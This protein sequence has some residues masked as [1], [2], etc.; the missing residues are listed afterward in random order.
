[1][2]FAYCNQKGGVG[3]TTTVYHH[4][5][6][7]ILAGM[8]VLVIDA[9]PQ[10]NITSSLTEDM[11]ESDAGVADALSSRSDL[12]LADV[13]V[14][15]IWDRL[16]VAPTVGDDLADVRNEL[17]I[18]A[19]PG[20]E[21][22]LRAQLEAI[23]GD[24]DLVLID[25]APSIDPLMI[26]ALTAAEA[27]VIVTESKLYSANGLAKLMTTVGQVREHY[28]PRL[29]VAG[30]VINA[31]EA[32]TLAGRHW[33]EV[34]TEAAEQAQLPILAPPV[35]KRQPIMD[36][37]ETARGLDEGD[38][39]SRELAE[40]YAAHLEQLMKGATHVEA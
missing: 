39:D 11:Q 20:R 15:G 4:A 22:R 23:R 29:V 40:I 10:G 33:A 32:H 3:K 35:P 34:L 36:T 1:M 17:A 2:I 19:E 8:R 31:H 9:D 30:L 27:V 6:A 28:N 13:L 37:T 18:T 25:C 26:N 7:A 24:Y 38:A 16:T 21:S 14:P 5:R 12:T